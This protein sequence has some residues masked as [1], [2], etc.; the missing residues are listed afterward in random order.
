MKVKLR[1]L[2]YKK[3]AR[4][5][6]RNTRV[7]CKKMPTCRG[8]I[9][10]HSRFRICIR[11]KFLYLCSCYFKIWWP[12]VTCTSLRRYADTRTCLSNSVL[13]S[14]VYVFYTALDIALPGDLLSIYT[15]EILSLGLSLQITRYSSTIEL[16]RIYPRLYPC[17][18][19]V[20]F[21]VHHISYHIFIQGVPY[22]GCQNFNIF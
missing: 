2:L 22:F 10:S 3:D 7:D 9:L 8:K 21:V 18:N 1:I 6:T 11:A 17:C 15:V 12:V 20:A 16:F 14:V 4:K 19:I 5:V 13:R